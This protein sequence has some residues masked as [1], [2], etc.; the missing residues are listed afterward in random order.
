[1]IEHG[2]NQIRNYLTQ[3]T[4]IPD[5]EWEQFRKLFKF[6]HVKKDENFVDAGQTDQHFAFILKGL[7]RFYF[8]T[9]DGQEYNQTFK[10]EGEMVVNY[11]PILAKAPSPFYIQ[12]I[13]DT[14][15]IYADYDDIEKLYDRHACWNT[16]GRKV[17]E[18][19]YMIKAN[20]EIQLLLF[21]ASDRYKNFIQAQPELAKRLPQY[22][23]ATYLGI[24]PSS[25]NRLI[26]KIEKGEA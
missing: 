1:M 19:N 16:L 26:K 7:V 14:D 13:E 4:E 15:L 25:L 6:R 24:N 10:R 22:H 2:L 21:D 5:S 3:L 8:T 20:R 18:I 23:L 17:I 11:Y 12:A 9:F